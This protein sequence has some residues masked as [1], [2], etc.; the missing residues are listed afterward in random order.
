MYLK[1]VH[2]LA[3]FGWMTGTSMRSR[4]ASVGHRNLGFGEAFLT[5]FS[6]ENSAFR[7]SYL[8][9]AE[10]RCYIRNVVIIGSRHLAG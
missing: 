6:P 3:A 4:F 8:S 1:A 10:D 2:L 5:Q 7:S 9:P